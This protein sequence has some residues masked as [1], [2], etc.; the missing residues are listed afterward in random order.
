MER[1]IAPGMIDRF[2]TFSYLPG[3]ETLFKGIRKL[4]P[5]NYLIHRD[6]RTEVHQ[7][8]DLNFSK[9]A[10]GP[11]PQAAERQLLDLLA[12]SVQSHMVSDVPVGVLLSGGAD[13]T[14]VL[15]FAAER[16]EQI[17][18]FT[19][20]FPDREIVD[21]RPFA[22]IAADRYKT[23]H[24]DMT[25]SAADFAAFLP[26]YVWHMEEPVCEP[27]AVAL[28]YVS[29]LAR[30][31]VKVLLS[32]EGGDEAFAG[33]SNYRNLIWLERFKRGVSPFHGVAALGL[34]IVGSMFR[35]PR[36]TK[37]GP[38]MNARFPDYYCSRTAYASRNSDSG[39]THLYRREFRETV[40][41]EHS[42][43]PL[44]RLQSRAGGLGTLDQMLY[45]DTKSWL[46]DDLLIKADKMT[47]ANSVEL[48]VPLLDH[49]VLEF[50][51]AL[52]ADLKVRGLTTKY[53]ARKTL[54]TRLPGAILKR[55]KAG[56]P[57]PY[58][59]W[60]R[61][62]L[63]HLVREV[64]FDRTTTER[65]YFDSQ[66]VRALLARDEVTGG[67][68][69]MIFSLLTLELCQRAFLDAVPQSAAVAHAQCQ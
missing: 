69:K 53:I 63:K 8:W 10:D 7:Y 43:E 56:F 29:K 34:S 18:T 37:Y 32:G 14:A 60:L 61:N 42:L 1:A 27:P 13:S 23:R 5:G 19:V 6:G 59:S 26:Q 51:A 30:N 65:G 25:M 47:M 31:Y 22:Q 68:S 66:A 20:G 50:A 64:F 46:P 41:H 54:G 36:L 17:S 67:H 16:A 39:I 9:P 57:V 33:Y 49:K 45:L 52:P 3:E 40:N 24:Y 2:L 58:E 55:P 35:L 62:D 4:A 11:T 38:L 21:E 12:E 44:R 28:Y 48:R 15:S